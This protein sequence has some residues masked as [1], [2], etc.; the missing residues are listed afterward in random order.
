MPET[1][2]LTG[3]FAAEAGD[4]VTPAQGL[5][6]AELTY[7]IAHE[8]R[9]PCTIIGGF[10]ALLNRLVKPADKEGEYARIIMQES[11]RMEKAIDAVLEFSQALGAERRQVELGD[12]AT[13]AV[14]EFRS[15]HALSRINLSVAAGD[16]S[17]SVFVVPDQ[18]VGALIEIM[19]HLLAASSQKLELELKVESESELGRIYLMPTLPDKEQSE[20]RALVASVVAPER[21][22][23]TLPLTLARESLRLNDCSLEL[24]AESSGQTYLYVEMPLSEGNNV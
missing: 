5:K 7:L 6:M 12:L 21:D 22:P 10:A 2:T 14:E 19:G 13:S 18:M 1:H 16:T 17:L 20:I 23:D 11:V 24:A 3:N 15:R 8:L 4:Q 9:N